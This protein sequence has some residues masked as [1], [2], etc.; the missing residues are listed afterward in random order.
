MINYEFLKN[1][2]LDAADE[3]YA[4]EYISSFVLYTKSESF[5]QK[6]LDNY[7]YLSRSTYDKSIRDYCKSLRKYFNDNGI[8]F[9]NNIF[10][11]ITDDKSHNSY[12]LA[13]TM[14]KYGFNVRV[15]INMDELIN[16][17]DIIIVDDYCG[18]GNTIGSVIRLIEDKFAGK[19]IYV[20]PFMSN[21]IG[22]C[23]IKG[24]SCTRNKLTIVE[25]LIN[26]K[27]VKYLTNEKI[28]SDDELKLFD[29]LNVEM[30]IEE[31]FKRGFNDME[32]LLSF[33]YFTPNTT[34]GFFWNEKG[35]NY[36]PLFGRSSEFEGD[37]KDNHK[38]A[39]I[40]NRYYGC[41]KESTSRSYRFLCVISMMI[42]DKGIDFAKQILSQ[43]ERFFNQRLNSCIN[44]GLIKETAGS[45]E[46][47]D[48]FSDFIDE[49]AFAI[50]NNFNS[51]FRRQ[52][53]IEFNL[54][55]TKTF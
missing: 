22:N 4:A 27:K 6:L 48:R 29:E 13:R 36:C 20:I 44:L 24:I 50:L 53:R 33:H 15:R 25:N 46:K 37:L 5:I 23:F 34:L 21:T 30:K 31:K 16:I 19:N 26:Y 12:F 51:N 52:E 17:E 40:L 11:P 41:V 28:L 35:F 42:I 9:E 47:G 43:M 39:S 54:N 38:R 10:L 49:E 8:D 14:K 55:L 2:K 32:D 7:I 18:S 1:W 45:F 3:A